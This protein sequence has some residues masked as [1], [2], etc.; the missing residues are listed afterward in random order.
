MKYYLATQQIRDGE[1]DYTDRFLL[2]AEDERKAES[3]A[4]ATIIED[5]GAEPEK[6]DMQENWLDLFDRIIK[7]I[8]V[9]EVTEQEANI[10]KKW[11]WFD[12]PH[13][14]S[15]TCSTENCYAQRAIAANIPL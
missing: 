10:L 15:N 1:H 6:W 5:Y 11:F 3:T 7:F 2:M 12:N 4:I 9:E 14:C 8:G 13:F